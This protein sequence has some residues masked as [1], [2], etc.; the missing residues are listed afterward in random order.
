MLQRNKR[1]SLISFQIERGSEAVGLNPLRTAA[2]M[3]GT[4]EK[5]GTD[6]SVIDEV[7]SKALGLTCQ[8]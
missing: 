8:P 6:V 5:T 4:W 1:P 7:T 3:I 2:L